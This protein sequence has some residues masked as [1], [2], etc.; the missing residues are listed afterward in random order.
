MQEF[1]VG[2]W[3]WLH[4]L[5]RQVMIVSVRGCSKLGPKYFGP[6][7][8]LERVNEVAY[9][10]RLPEHARIHDFFHVCVLKPFHGEPPSSTLSLPPMLHGHVIPQ[11]RR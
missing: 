7:E 10:P 6:Y 8:V 5:H 9:H 3:V 4:L 11:P 1:S 2:Q